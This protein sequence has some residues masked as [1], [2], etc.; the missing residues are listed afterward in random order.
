MSLLVL[1]RLVRLLELV[2]VGAALAL[3]G[4]GGGQRAAGVLLG[5]AGRCQLHAH[6]L[7]LLAALARR[8]L[9]QHTRYSYSYTSTRTGDYGAVESGE[10]KTRRSHKLELR[11]RQDIG[12][13]AAR[14]PKCPCGIV[15]R[16]H[17]RV[18]ARPRYRRH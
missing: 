10:T 18:A 11:Q 3:G 17:T 14:A 9:R 7:Q 13:S 1:Q 2:V 16:L 5:R 4:G 12:V 8:A 6:S 15:Q